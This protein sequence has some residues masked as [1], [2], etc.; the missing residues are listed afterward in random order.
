MSKV[1]LRLVLLAIV[2]LGPTV[3]RAMLDGGGG[4]TPL[5]D[6]FSQHCSGQQ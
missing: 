1:L 3:S 4:P 2:T 5:C 6:P